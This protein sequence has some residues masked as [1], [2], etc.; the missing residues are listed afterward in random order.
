MA[1]RVRQAERRGD[2][3]RRDE[4]TRGTAV[5]LS[6]SYALYM[7]NKRD[8]QRATLAPHSESEDTDTGRLCG[9]RAAQARCVAS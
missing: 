9:C 6:A 5:R 8:I 4:R 3:G 2:R 1:I 7:Y